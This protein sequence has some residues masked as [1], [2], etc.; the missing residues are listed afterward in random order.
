MSEAPATVTQVLGRFVAGFSGVVGL[1]WI[2]FR[3]RLFQPWETAFSVLVIGA[4]A[5]AILAALR[6]RR[7]SHAVAIAIGY[8]VFQLTL[9]NVRGLMYASTGIV[10]ASGLL[11]TGWIFDQLGRL[12]WSVGKFLIYGPMVAG[13]FL[14]VAPMMTYNTL[15]SDNVL[16]TFLVYLY[17]GLVTGHGVGLGIEAADLIGRAFS[18]T[19]SA[20]TEVKT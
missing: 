2:A 8:A 7:G 12:G 19:R 6:G 10:I 16:R 11:I 4:V 1:G 14:A 15:T 3:E 18:K 5:A 9:W 17:M 13:I 20:T